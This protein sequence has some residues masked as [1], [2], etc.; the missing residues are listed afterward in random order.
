MMSPLLPTTF[1]LT[2]LPYL[3]SAVDFNQWMAPGPNDVRSPCP[4]LNSLA[5]H[6]ICPRSG[7]GYTVEIL[8]KCLKDGLNVGHDFST[9]IGGAAL[10]AAAPLASSF[11]LDQIRE[12]NFPI[13]HDASLSREDYYVSADHDN[14][15]F[16]QTIFDQVLAFYDGMNKTSIPVA[17]KAKYARVQT[18]NKEDPK[19]HGHFNPFTWRKRRS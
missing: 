7:K 3:A 5:N 2:L 6:G 15:R 4:G 18:E 17:A 1:L 11:S 12:H 10:L 14:W 16:N 19:V 13:E 9:A 8:N